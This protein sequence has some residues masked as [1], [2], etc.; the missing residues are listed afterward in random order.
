[1]DD[2]RVLEAFFDLFLEVKKNACG[3][4]SRK[5]AI[6]GAILSLVKSR[7]DSPQEAP[8]ADNNADHPVQSTQ[9]EDVEMMKLDPIVAQDTEQ[10]QHIFCWGWPDD[11]DATVKDHHESDKMYEAHVSLV[12]KVY[13]LDDEDQKLFNALED[14]LPTEMHQDLLGAV[15]STLQL[16]MLSTS[17][18]SLPSWSKGLS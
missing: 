13:E 18:I 8:K 12:L 7:R 2:D 5:S 16:N 15:D 6:I 3:S 10:M 4:K 17:S 14:Y 9:S 11:T 1:M